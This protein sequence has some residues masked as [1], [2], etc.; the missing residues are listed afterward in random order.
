MFSVSENFGGSAPKRTLRN[1]ENKI[2]RQTS[3]NGI[4]I[5]PAAMRQT[6]KPIS[7]MP[8]ERAVR[9]WK[10]VGFLIS[11]SSSAVVT[12]VDM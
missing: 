3:G 2:Q 4:N 7:K 12:G 9:D 10:H 11:R 5:F 1:P 8:N 6:K